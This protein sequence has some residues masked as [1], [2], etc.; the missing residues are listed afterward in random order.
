[1]TLSGKISLAALA[2]RIN[3]PIRRHY[4]RQER[5]GEGRL[6]GYRDG[7]AARQQPLLRYM[8][9]VRLIRVF[10]MLQRSGNESRGK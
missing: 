8:V 1:M 2:M 9:W 4:W 10:N 7:C 5:R 3:G 6:S